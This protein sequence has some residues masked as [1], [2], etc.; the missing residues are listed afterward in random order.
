MCSA[1]LDISSQNPLFTTASFHAE[2]YFDSHFITE[3]EECSACELRVIVGDDPVWHSKAEDDPF[4]EL[5]RC[6]GCLSWYWHH[7]NP[8]GEL[9]DSDEPVLVSSH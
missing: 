9:V 2:A 1:H 6:L 5:D 8:L 7:F 3:F 4:D